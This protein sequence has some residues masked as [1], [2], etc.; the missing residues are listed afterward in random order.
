MYEF[1]R[2]QF[3]FTGKTQKT[4]NNSTFKNPKTNSNDGRQFSTA[5]LSYAL[6]RANVRSVHFFVSSTENRYLWWVH[7]SSI[8]DL[9]K[10][11]AGG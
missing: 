9:R 11:M 6:H 2:N 4:G 5:K 7:R 1:H 10:E 8:D 3:N